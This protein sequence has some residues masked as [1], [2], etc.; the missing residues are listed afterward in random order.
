MKIA[1]IAYIATAL[2]SI[3]ATMPAHAAAAPLPGTE[4]SQEAQPQS[5][6][7]P[8]A[9]P[10]VAAEADATTLE[11]RRLASDRRSDGVL[12]SIDANLPGLTREVDVRAR[13]S[14]SILAQRP[15]LELLRDLDVRWQDLRATLSAHSERL[16]GVIAGLERDV[17]SL[18]QLERTWTA[19]LALARQENAPDELVQRAQSLLSEIAALRKTVTEQR[20]SALRAQTRVSELELRVTE[21]LQ[22]NRRARDATVAQMFSRD[23]APLWQSN[24]RENAAQRISVGATDSFGRQWTILQIYFAPRAGRALA[25]V[26]LLGVLTAVFFGVRRRFASFVEQ[27]PGLRR[28]AAVVEHPIA[29]ALILTLLVTPW[30]YPQAPRL[31]WAISGVAMLVPTIIVLRK[32]VSDYLVAPLY[33]VLAFFF[34]DQVRAVSAS[35]DIIPRL[36]LM[37]EMIAA[38]AF[39]LWFRRK[40]TRDSHP[41]LAMRRSSPLAVAALT[42]AVLCTAAALA[43]AVGNVALS[44]LVGNAVLDSMYVGLVLYTVVQL[45]DALIVIAMR[46]RPLNALGMV[47]AHRPLLRRRTKRV[48]QWVAGAIWALYLLD[49]LAIRDRVLEGLRA[50]LDAQLSLGEIDISLSSVL[51]FVLAVWAAFLI[52]RFIRFVLNEEVFPRTHLSRGIPYAITRAIHFLIIALGFIIAMGVIGMEMTQFTIL[53]S[54]FTIGVGFGL[55]NIFNNFVS[56]LI[57]LFERPVQV[58][59]VIQIDNDIGVVERIGIRATVVRT[60]NRSEIIV[61]NGKLISDRVV[62]W[63]L[64]GRQRIIEVPVSVVLQ[65]DPAQVISVLEAMAKKHPSVLQNPPPEAILTRAGPDWM[66]FELRAAS[67][68]VERWTTVRSELGASAIAALRDAGIALR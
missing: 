25:Q 44:N 45:L 12:E 16:K 64:S 40:A 49:R 8:I 33:A 15:S 28:I 9:L 32:L 34:V 57:V 2:W 35:I 54:A 31:L 29:S 42:A 10:Q 39:L 14:R 24:W 23:S 13:E 21:A 26:A 62:N 19:T 56:G 11:L 22:A 68:E 55:Q 1:V 30:I 59:D 18:E 58:G 3:C 66:G 51:S 4:K 36:L 47:R 20:T 61:P 48:L 53:A 37:L 50:V 27:E 5:A 67:A 6:A 43:N 46:V 17:D 7:I 65:S 52:S 38:V 60:T 63:T 41:D